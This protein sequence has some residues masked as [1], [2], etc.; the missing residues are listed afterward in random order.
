MIIQENGK[1]QDYSASPVKSPPLTGFINNF[2]ETK[3]PCGGSIENGGKVIVAS[4]NHWS[5]Q[6]I[7]EWT[8]DDQQPIKIDQTLWD[9]EAKRVQVACDVSKTGKLI[10]HG[11]D[12]GKYFFES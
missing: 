1:V 7:F 2:G 3:S 4:T 10:K 6:P 9:T 11:G 12:N 8:L 5:V